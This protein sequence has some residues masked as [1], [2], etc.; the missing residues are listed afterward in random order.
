MA[1]NFA[2]S[3]AYH[4]SPDRVQLFPVLAGQTFITGALV[5]Y[6]SGTITECGADPTSILGI[7]L[8]PAS[9]GLAAAG[10]IYGGTNIPVFVIDPEDVIVM[11]S[12]TTP[13]YATHVNTAYG[14]VK[15]TNWLID[16]SEVTTTSVK[17]INVSITPERWF[18]RFDAAK[19]QFDQI[20]S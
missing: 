10:S 8:A 18:V 12:A 14:L 16:V 19:L 4:Y 3:P 5:V 9:V 20:A 11:A 2:P 1:T 17:A 15:S 6:A 13:V 7:A